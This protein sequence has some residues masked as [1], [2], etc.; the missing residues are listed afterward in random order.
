M[1]FGRIVIAA[2]F[3]CGIGLN[4]GLII[5]ALSEKL[6]ILPFVFPILFSFLVYRCLTSIELRRFALSVI[7]GVI[8]GFPLGFI[9]F[10][11]SRNDMLVLLPIMLSFLL[12]LVFYRISKVDY[13]KAAIFCLALIVLG[14]TFLWF[15]SYFVHTP[16]VKY[17]GISLPG[18]VWSLI[19]VG[20]GSWF[21]AAGIYS[22]LK[23]KHVIAVKDEMP[24]IVTK[25]K[26]KVYLARTIVFMFGSLLILT[27]IMLI[28]ILEGSKVPTWLPVV[29]ASLGMF[30][31]GIAVDVKLM[32]AILTFGGNIR[33]W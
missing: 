32:N 26:F 2:F 33:I 18:F 1:K 29:F 24:G 3:G 5:Y 27:S 28:T 15:S 4:L 31:I 9:I 20:L 23:I 6:W 19:Y 7:L 12:P 21:F 17:K 8:V 14:L 16:W 30:L 11:I 25:S 10:A 22:L 13:I